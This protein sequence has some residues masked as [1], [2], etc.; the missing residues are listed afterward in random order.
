MS[1]YKL[2]LKYPGSSKIGTEVY[3]VPSIKG[4]YYKEMSSEITYSREEIEDYPDHW[5]KD[6]L[7]PLF[8]TE[9]N[10]FIYDGDQYWY[11]WFDGDLKQLYQKPYEAYSFI[12]RESPGSFIN[13][14]T[15]S[16]RE[17]ANS[18]IEENKPQFSKKDMLS[19]GKFVGGMLEFTNPESMLNGWIKIN[20][21]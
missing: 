20:K 14:K 7:A 18:W 12:A 13:S 15:F 2:Q 1:R 21:K 4:Y 6:F 9:D 5:I 11:V 3:K 10:V 8:T 19:F 17:K 16:T